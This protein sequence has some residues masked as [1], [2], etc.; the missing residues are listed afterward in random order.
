MTTTKK[1]LYDE[2]RV[3]LIA[4]YAWAKD[5]ARLSR[6]MQSVRDTLN[7]GNTFNR[8]GEAWRAACHNVGISPRISLKALHA[9]PIGE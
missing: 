3:Q 8:D 1:A 4:G 5:E 6:F 2:Y 7:G 9:L